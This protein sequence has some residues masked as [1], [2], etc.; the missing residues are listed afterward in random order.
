MDLLGSSLSLDAVLELSAG[1]SPPGD[2][3]PSEDPSDPSCKK[4]AR[5]TSA[6]EGFE[7]P[8]DWGWSL[9]SMTEVGW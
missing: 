8:E 3:D 1:H 4:G 6:E 7:L 5:S 9:A 2:N